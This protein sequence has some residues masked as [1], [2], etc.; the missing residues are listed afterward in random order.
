[1]IVAAVFGAIGGIE[2]VPQEWR[3]ALKNCRPQDGVTGVEQPRDEVFWPV[4]A[5]LLAQ[6]LTE[7]TPADAA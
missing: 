1:V 5:E 2:Q 7:L 4:E 3:D 6:Q